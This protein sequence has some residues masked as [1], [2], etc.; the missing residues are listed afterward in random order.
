VRRPLGLLAGLPLY[1][2]ASARYGSYG[3]TVFQINVV[4]SYSPTEPMTPAEGYPL[5][6]AEP[7][8]KPPDAIRAALWAW[9]EHVSDDPDRRLRITDVAIEEAG[10]PLPARLTMTVTCEIDAPTEWDARTD[11][12][13]LFREER[14]T[15]TNEPTQSH[16]REKLWSTTPIAVSPQHTGRN[17]LQVLSVLNKL[18]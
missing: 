8:V 7:A 9:S 13:S 3:M 4:A 2:T 6:D 14:A 10:I 12:V 15:S 1:R 11:A 16:S 5:L 18:R 17:T